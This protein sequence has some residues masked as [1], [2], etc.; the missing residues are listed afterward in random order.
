MPR[1]LEHRVYRY[2]IE[3]LIE[4]T[5]RIPFDGKAEVLVGLLFDGFAVK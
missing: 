3:R 1:K 4:G 5:S 2:P